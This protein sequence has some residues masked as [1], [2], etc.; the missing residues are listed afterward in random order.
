MTDKPKPKVD[1]G[2]LS[3]PEGNAYVVMG[4]CQEAAKR[5]GWSQYEIESAMARMRAGNYQHLLA[6]AA[7]LFDVRYKR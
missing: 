2:Y 4:R 1:L 3:G 6:T 7:E 5:A